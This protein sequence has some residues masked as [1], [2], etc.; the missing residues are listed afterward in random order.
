MKLTSKAQFSKTGKDGKQRNFLSYFLDGVLIFKQKI[1]FNE[2]M[3]HGFDRRTRIYDDYLLNGKIH[4]TRM[5]IDT[6]KVREVYF[7]VSKEILK[8]LN[9]PKDL[10]I[11]CQ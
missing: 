10:K 4:Q 7:P 1:S 11:C 3:E 5:N 6:R 2:K 9:V 8:K